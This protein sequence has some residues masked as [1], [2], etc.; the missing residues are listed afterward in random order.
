MISL[1]EFQVLSSVSG[2]LAMVFQKFG[3]ALIFLSFFDKLNLL[4]FLKI[5]RVIIGKKV[6]K[7]ND[8][9]SSAVDIHT[10][11]ASAG[12]I[13]PIKILLSNV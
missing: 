3:I 8:Q 4:F 1:R 2:S 13:P 10:G 12:N 9:N 7:T 5:N 11:K 6:A